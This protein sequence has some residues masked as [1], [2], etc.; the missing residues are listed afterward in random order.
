MSRGFCHLFLLRKYSRIKPQGNPKYE[1]RN[2]K[3]YQNIKYKLAI[4]GQLSVLLYTL[5]LALSPQGRTFW[6]KAK[7]ISACE[8]QERQCG[9]CG[10]FLFR[11]TRNGNNRWAQRPPYRTGFLYFGDF[12]FT[13]ILNTRCSAQRVD[14][15]KLGYF[16]LVILIM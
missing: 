3:Q 16:G 5:T 9:I 8:P 14:I 1:Y 2:T 11:R 10:W 12:G 15:L 13:R 7:S 4:S 6:P